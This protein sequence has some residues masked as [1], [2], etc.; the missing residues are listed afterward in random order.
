MRPLVKAAVVASVAPTVIAGGVS[1]SSQHTARPA[2][3]RVQPGDTL[4]SIAARFYSGDP[5]ATVW[6]IEQ[7]NQLRGA[8]IRPGESLRL[9]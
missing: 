7:T 3:V 8:D 4:W 9:P 6:R 5:R 2:S 1:A